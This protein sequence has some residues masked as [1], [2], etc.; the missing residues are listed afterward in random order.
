ML[1]AILGA[2]NPISVDAQ[3]LA[4]DV[5]A[6]TVR[7]EGHFLGHPD[8]YARMKSDFVYPE[9]ANRQAPD[10]WLANGAPTINDTAQRAAKKTL[11]EHFPDHIPPDID[12]RIRTRFDIKLPRERMCQA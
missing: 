1:G 3:T 2:A 5:I 7:G 12:E 4:V 6:Q 9:L 8:T 11:A 10:A